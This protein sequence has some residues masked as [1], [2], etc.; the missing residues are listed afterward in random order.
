[1]AMS[2]GHFARFDKVRLRD[3]T[4]PMLQRWRN[5]LVAGYSPAYARLVFGHFA[6]VLDFAVK[7]R[8][9]QRNVARQ[10]GSVRKV[11]KEVDSGCVTSSSALPLS[12]DYTLE[13][14]EATVELGLRAGEAPLYI[15]HFSQ[16]EALKNARSLASYGVSEK[17]QRE[18]IKQAMKGTKFTTPFGKILQRLLA[19]GVGVHHAGM[20][21]ATGFWWSAWPSRGSCPSSAAPTPWAWAS[22]CPSTP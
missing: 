15:V 13:T 8:L 11:P 10:V 19:A 21:R 6:M 9:L 12:Y 4:A 2:R 17:D 5:E 18:A 22:T 7:L 14:L 3:I 1:M 20:R 16:D